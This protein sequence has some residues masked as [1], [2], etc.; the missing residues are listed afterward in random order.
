MSYKPLRMQDIK[1][2][3]TYHRQGV[4]KKK[5][6]RLLGLSKNTVKKYI[7]TSKEVND[8][9]HDEQIEKCLSTTGSSQEQAK[10]KDLESRY[11]HLIGELGRV[12]VTRYLLWEEYIQSYPEGYSYSSFCRRLSAYKSSQDVTIRIEH[13]AAYKLSVDYTGKRVSWVDRSTGEEYRAEVLV[14]TM[15]YSNYTFACAVRSQKQEDFIHAINQALLYIG[16]IPKVLESD[17]LKSY[18]K[19]PTDTNPYLQNYAHNYPVIMV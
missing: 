19:K 12:G 9:H 11:E 7:N 2:I 18:V 4:P 17:N 16:G 1:K 15:P 14:C 13:K 3:L 5:I 10:A 6:A 8:I